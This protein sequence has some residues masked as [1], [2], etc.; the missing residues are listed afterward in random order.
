MVLSE[1]AK[2]SLALALRTKDVLTS[3]SELRALPGV[4]CSTEQTF[5]GQ[6]SIIV[7]LDSF[8]VIH[9]LLPKEQISLIYIEPEYISPFNGS[10][11][12]RRWLRLRGRNQRYYDDDGVG[13]SQGMYHGRVGRSYRELWELNVES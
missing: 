12:P 5:C 4:V 2:C 13:D 6:A 8:G 9:H 3:N 10:C 11:T 7:R 1:L